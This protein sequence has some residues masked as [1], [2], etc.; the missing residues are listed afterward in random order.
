MA[1]SELEYTRKEIHL[2][3]FGE[4][5]DKNNVGNWVKTLVTRKE[6]YED[7]TVTPYVVW[8]EPK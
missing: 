2:E 1:P 6:I 4:T 7:R 8:W 5:G 3:L